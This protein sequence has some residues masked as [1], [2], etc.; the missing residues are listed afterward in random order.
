MASAVNSDVV[1]RSNF[2]KL[3]NVYY[4]AV[5]TFLRDVFCEMWKSINGSEWEGDKDNGKKLS[6]LK[7]LQPIFKNGKLQKKKVESG[8]CR[9]W[10]LSL[11]IDIFIALKSE[12]PNTI[13]PSFDNSAFTKNNLEWLKSTRNILAHASSTEMDQAQFQPLWDKSV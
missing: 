6:G 5:P 2:M 3:H 13:L 12:N 9:L 7:A 10:D 11:L 1:C 4:Q 8:N